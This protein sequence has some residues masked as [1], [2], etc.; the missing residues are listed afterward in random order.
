VNGRETAECYG[1]LERELLE[2]R[3]AA[4]HRVS[5]TLESL[6]NS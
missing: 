4:L 6:I 3:A 2:E 1:R 5:Q